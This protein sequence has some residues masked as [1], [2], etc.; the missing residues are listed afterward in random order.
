MNMENIVIPGLPAEY[1]LIVNT[2]IGLLSAALVGPATAI[3]KKW[4]KTEGVTTVAVSAALSTLVAVGVMIYQAAQ[5][6]LSWSGVIIGL[7]AFIRSNGEYLKVRQA[8]K[9]AVE[10]AVTNPQPLPTVNDDALGR[11]ATADDIGPSMEVKY[12]KPK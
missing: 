1:A 11:P 5:G 12:G 10:K 2:V 6:T 8:T 7:I 9:G 3:A 4:F